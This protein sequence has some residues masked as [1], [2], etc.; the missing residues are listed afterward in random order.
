[1]SRRETQ[2]ISLTLPCRMA[3]LPDSTPVLLALSGGADSVTLLHLLARARETHGFSLFLAHVHHG[4]R[5]AEADRDREFCALLAQ[6]YGCEIFFLDAD[7][8]ALAR[9]HGRSEEEEGRIVRYAFF[10]RLMR[11]KRIPLLATAHHADDNLETLLFRLLRGTGTRGLAGIPP[12]RT[13]G[14]GYL[15]RPLLSVTK[16]E[17]LAYCQDEGVYFVTDSTNEAPVCTRN[18]IRAELLPVLHSLSQNASH[19]AARAQAALAEDNALLDSLA[20][21]LYERARSETG[22]RLAPLSDAPVPL[23]K[24]ALL[25]FYAEFSDAEPEALH[26]EEMLALVRTPRANRALSLPASLRFVT[27]RGEARILPAPARKATP[28]AP[29]LPQ[30]LTVGEMTFPAPNGESIRISVRRA[31]EGHTNHDAP[32]AT[33][34]TRIALPFAI[35]HQGAFFRTRRE[36]DSLLLG[37]MH[38]PLRR[39]L[40]ARGIPA[41]LRDSLPLLCDAEGILWTPLV[42]ARD[43]VLLTEGDALLIDL[44]LP[45]DFFAPSHSHPTGGTSCPRSDR[46]TSST[47]GG[48]Q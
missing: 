18:R 6:K 29:P 22:L 45:N 7:V 36:G 44:T 24:R 41:R 34:G 21:D 5:G 47:N 42:G 28:A 20:D 40:A 33:E 13:F 27:E 39:L 8:P 16:A 4:I 1:M 2:S 46:T 19:A 32:P 9:E 38:R 26:V 25:R 23:C 12:V 15:T 3:G 37:T 48:T 14:N 17:I 43:G 30:P 31:E 35:L 11:E 10:E